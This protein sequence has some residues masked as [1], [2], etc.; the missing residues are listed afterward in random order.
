MTT[1]T[2]AVVVGVLFATGTYLVLR[3]SPIKL[4]LGLGLLSHAVNL[5]LFGTSGLRHA[6]PP[7]LDKATFN[8]ELVD[9]VDPL[10]QALILTAIVISFGVTA[11][12]VVLVN[13]RHTLSKIVEPETN[14]VPSRQASDPFASMDH[15]LTGLDQDPDDYEWLE[16]T[17]ADQFA[18]AS[19]AG[20]ERE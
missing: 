17:L 6:A 5:L 13:R 12:T 7:I 4:I 9:V 19:G 20:S 16:F 1:L 18:P 14:E 2:L 11:F 8:G 10:P 3:R 15:Y